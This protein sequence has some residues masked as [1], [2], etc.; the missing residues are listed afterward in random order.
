M[1][2]EFFFLTEIGAVVTKLDCDDHCSKLSNCLNAVHKMFVV[3]YY[4]FWGCVVCFFVVVSSDGGSSNPAYKMAGNPVHG[5][6][7]IISNLKFDEGTNLTSDKDTKLKYRAG[8]EVDEVN[9]QELFGSKY[10]NYKVVFLKNLKRDQIDMAFKLVSGHEGFT[11]MHLGKIDRETL[12][13]LSSADSH[14]AAGHDSFVCCLMSHGAKGVVYG[15]DKE[16][17]DLDNIYNYLGEC[18]HLAGKPKMIF[19]QACQGSA[20]ADH[21]GPEAPPPPPVEDDGESLFTT[22]TADFLVSYAAFYG[23]KS[24]RWMEG[25]GSWYMSALCNTFKEKYKSKDV[26]SMIT[27]VHNEVMKQKSKDEKGKM[28][29]QIPRLEHTLRHKVHLAVKGG[30]FG[31]K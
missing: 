9:L 26:V 7:L 18:K 3:Q 29:L 30:W 27:D 25:I 2:L 19:I 16:T 14:I 28:C 6:A 20:T 31:R 12:K 8:G 11:Y 22:K 1:Y 21:D 13:A 24:F 5:I 17:F 23:Q 15:T 4:D 10:L